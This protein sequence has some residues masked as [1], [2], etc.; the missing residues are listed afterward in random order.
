MEPVILKACKN[1]YSF[2]RGMDETNKTNQTFKNYIYNNETNYFEECFH[3]CLFCSLMKSSSSESQH[4]CLACSDGYQKSYE[5]MGN[6]YKIDRNDNSDKIISNKGDE[7]FTSVS[8]CL[9]TSKKYKIKSTG[10]C[11]SECPS[12]SPYKK[13]TYQYID[14]FKYDVDLSIPQCILEDEE[15]PKYLFRNLCLERCPLGTELNES[16]NE[17]ISLQDE[18]TK[19]PYFINDIQIFTDFCTVYELLNN[20]CRINYKI[21]DDLRNISNNIETIIYDDSLLGNESIVISG[22]YIDY[23]IITSDIDIGQ[24]NNYNISY[25][26]F[27]ECENK[28]KN[29]YK[30]DNLL[31]FKYDVHINKS[32]PLKT[33]YKIFNPKTKKQLNL[34]IC[35]DKKILVSAPLLLEKN[36]L[37]LYYEFLE[38]GIDIFNKDDRFFYDIC[39]T[40]TT[41]VST[42]IILS[43]RRKDYYQGNLYLCDKGCDFI[44]YDINNNYVKCKCGIKYYTSDKIEIIDFNF[45]KEELSSFF[46]IKTYANVA[47]LKCYYLLLKKE[48]FLFNIGNFLILFLLLL[49][50]L[51]MILLYRKFESNIKK[52]ILEIIPLVNKSLNSDIAR[53]PNNINL[54][55]NRIIK[56]IEKKKEENKISI[57]KIEDK[58]VIKSSSNE[59]ISSHKLILKNMPK[60]NIFKGKDNDK[61]INNDNYIEKDILKDE[62]LN[63]LEYEKAK[64]I[65]KRNFWQF[66]ISLLM[67]KHLLLFSFIP[68]ND[69]NLMFIKICLFL[70]IFSLNFAVNALFFTDLTMHEIYKDKGVFNLLYQLPKILYSA[71]ISAFLNVS[72]KFLVLSENNILKLKQS[73]TKEELNQKVEQTISCLKLKFNLFYIFGIIFLIIFW[74]Y[75]SVFCATYKNTQIILI[76]DTLFSFLVLLLYPFALYIIPSFFRILSIKNKNSPL[77]Y[78]I[79]KIISLF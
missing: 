76:E 22:E 58:S 3:T 47:C 16:N 48:G 32:F 29:Y 24:R 20:I 6:C 11:V 27:G 61:K 60:D 79:S 72:I 15:V 55:K 9:E 59:N 56:N 52:F 46:N 53:T 21:G 28:L 5:Y 10:E 12:I 51:L 75:V 38:K 69:Y 30:I 39:K 14:F 77:L 62:E 17:C 71:I 63:N 26:D 34:S 43:D 45:K 35:N 66:Y 78:K 73:K 7:S 8:S 37:D 54:N 1:E 65:D 13:Y 40:F 41:N 44:N 68:V 64:I 42:D 33:E 70:F 74:Y 23:E 36:C 4:N 49:F 50:I 25:I 18:E 57:E 67:K 19:L 31:I 2:F